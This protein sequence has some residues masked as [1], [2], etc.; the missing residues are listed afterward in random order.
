MGSAAH[1]TLLLLLHILLS[2][3]VRPIPLIIPLLEGGKKGTPD[4]PPAAAGSEAVRIIL[5]TEAL[6][7]FSKQLDQD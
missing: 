6:P 7:L 4:F 5:P 2:E 3:F 1:F